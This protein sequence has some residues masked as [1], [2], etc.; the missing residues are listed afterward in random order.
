MN[1]IVISSNDVL[2]NYLGTFF[3]MG[4]NYMLLPFFLWHFSD[5]TLGLWYVYMSLSNM[6]ALLI[7]GFSPSFSRNIAYCWNGA[8]ELTATGKTDRSLG[9][10]VDVH[11][12]DTLMDAC[13]KVYLFIGL[14]ALLLLGSIGTIYIYSIA[15][16][17][18]S[19]GLFMAWGVMVIAIFFNI[20]LG[21]YISL[22]S[23]IGYVAERN[24]AQV[25]A[26]I[27]RIILTGVLLASGMDLLGACIAYLL[28]G[29]FLRMICKK[30]F[31][32]AINDRF[33]GYEHNSSIDRKEIMDC[34]RIIWPNTWRDGV[35]SISEYLI[36][37][38]GTIICSL[39]L[40][41]AETGIYSLSV[42]LITAIGKIARSFQIAY[43]PA[44]QTAFITDNKKDSKELHAMCVSVFC[45]TY[46]LGVTALY[47]IGLPLLRIIRPDMVIDKAVL[48]GIAVLQFIV[49]LRNCYASYLST[50][51]RLDYWLAY[52]LSGCTAVI[53]S[54]ISFECYSL[55]IWSI[56]LPAI[57]AEA[58]YNTWYWPYKVHKELD[59]KIADIFPVGLKRLRN[60]FSKGC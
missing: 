4:I 34:L 47:L 26:G 60:V 21:Y 19:R 22:L 51:N 8:E 15:G 50:T 12:F 46:V 17:L 10:G 29:F 30:Y 45:I 40:T 58:V 36:T 7:F 52:I 5:D 49:I 53:V 14:I 57:L 59:M 9:N 25:I 55:G 11:L 2:W 23:G 3:S 41:L 35:V 32:N 43:I 20:Y 56:I 18:R 1:K 28:Y 42:Q 24:K 6:A 33:P 44:L 54:V 13:N 31:L 38:A 16:P 27:I 37:Q 39:F 48:L